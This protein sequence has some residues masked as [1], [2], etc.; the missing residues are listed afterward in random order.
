MMLGAAARIGLVMFSHDL[1]E[2][3]CAAHKLETESGG[4]WS[5]CVSNGKD[6]M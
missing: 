4:R 3:V 2:H 1:V 5:T 6:A